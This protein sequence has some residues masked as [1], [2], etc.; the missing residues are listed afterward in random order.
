VPVRAEVRFAAEAARAAAAEQAAVAEAILGFLA[1]CQA[2]VHHVT[3]LAPSARAAEVAAY[4][5]ALGPTAT[6]V[7]TP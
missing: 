1:G 6:E 5:R 2:P 3:A 4:L 7:A